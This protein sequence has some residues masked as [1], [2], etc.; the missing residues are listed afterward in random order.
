MTSSQRV[1]RLLGTGSVA[2]AAAALL[3]LAPASAALSA[4]GGNVE[5]VDFSASGYTVADQSPTGQNG[6]ASP[7]TDTYDWALVDNSSFPASD[8][9]TEGRSLRLSNWISDTS[10][11][12]N[13][14]QLTGPL[15][16]D[17]AGEA[18]TG[19]TH[20]VFDASF[21][22]ASA[23]GAIQERLAT[24][25]TIDDGDGSR[26]GNGI[27]LLHSEE[28]LQ[29]SAAW[30]NP[31]TPGDDDDDWRTY[32][33]PAYDATV[34]HQIRM[35][36]EYVPGDTSVGPDTFKV[37]LDG[38]VVIEGYTYEG[39]HEYKES[40]QEIR[41]SRTLLFRAARSLP[42]PSGPPF[43]GYLATAA[44][45]DEQLAA[46][47]GKGFLF[48]DIQYAA[49]TSAPTSEPTLP[50]EPEPATSG[51]DLVTEAKQP[52]EQQPFEASGFEPFENVAVTVYSTPYFAGWFRADI[53]GVVSG[54]FTL[55]AGIGAR[56]HTLQA[57]GQTSGSIATTRFTLALADTGAEPPLGALLG[58]CGMLL[59]GGLALAL[60]ARRARRAGA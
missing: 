28:G 56:T 52:G 2:A 12:G 31:E 53:N 19:A 10:L 47:K 42:Q 16:A 23:T 59:A 54:S 4:T 40:P 49:Y 27:V 34:P 46:L 24:S 60:T 21:T 32:I 55:P 6:W 50:P 22:V 33:T 14:V 43:P 25:V 41:T 44:P 36:S 29:I 48:S 45:T 20:N 39:Y 3:A 15:L 38:E 51:T 57:V 1:P 7:Y 8:L 26:S 58:G 5:V 18:A 30:V 17:F 35:V 9:P 13:M 37:Y 11:Y